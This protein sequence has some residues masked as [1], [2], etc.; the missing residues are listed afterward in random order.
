MPLLPPKG[1]F[2]AAHGLHRPV[3]SGRWLVAHV[4]CMNMMPITALL[5]VPAVLVWV[6]F[7]PFGALTLPVRSPRAL[8]CSKLSSGC[9]LLRLAVR[10]SWL[11]PRS[12]QLRQR[13]AEPC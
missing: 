12:L 10:L 1:R 8:I 9:P 11:T 6:V 13:S 5:F 4:G 3:C 7:I 2:P